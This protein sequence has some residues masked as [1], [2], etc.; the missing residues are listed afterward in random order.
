MLLTETQTICYYLLFN[1]KNF[2][3]IFWN[4]L[5][6][7]LCCLKFRYNYINDLVKINKVFFN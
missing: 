3:K 7:K 1:K 6:D 4:S 2:T 5:R